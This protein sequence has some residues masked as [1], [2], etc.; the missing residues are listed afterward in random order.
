MTV[1]IGRPSGASVGPAEGIPLAG[2]LLLRVEG[3]CWCRQGRAGAAATGA[4]G[5]MAV[6]DASTAGY[7]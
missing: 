7:C 1:A 6:A 5:L 3:L 4:G 2:L